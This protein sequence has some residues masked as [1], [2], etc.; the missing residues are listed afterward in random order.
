MYYSSIYL[1]NVSDI[2]T[3]VNN[4]F[5]RLINSQLDTLHDIY[6]QIWKFEIL[7]TGQRSKG[8]IDLLKDKF[9]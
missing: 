9:D 6:V 3:T 1:I 5:T 7:N 8:K 4:D 2:V